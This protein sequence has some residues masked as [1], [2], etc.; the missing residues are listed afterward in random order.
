MGIDLCNMHEENPQ[1]TKIAVIMEKQPF[2]RQNGHHN[3]LHINYYTIVCCKFIY[4]CICVLK[5]LRVADAHS[6]KICCMII[7]SMFIW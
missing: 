7:C 5:L 4:P 3:F 6:D 1:K 2:F